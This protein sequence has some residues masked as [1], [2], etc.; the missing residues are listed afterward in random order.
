[1]EH[2]QNVVVKHFIYYE[3]IKNHESRLN[4]FALLINST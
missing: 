2:N 1:M 4:K 3:Q